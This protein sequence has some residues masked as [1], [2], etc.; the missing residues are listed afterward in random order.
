MPK[1]PAF[2]G[3]CGPAAALLIFAA[4]ILLLQLAN[5]AMLPLMAGVV[6]QRGF[7]PLGGR[8]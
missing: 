7:E 5:G 4:S 2:S 3:W 1:R 8:C 6:D